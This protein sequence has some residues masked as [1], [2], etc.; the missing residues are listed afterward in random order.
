MWISSTLDSEALYLSHISTPHNFTY[1]L[2]NLPCRDGNI[3]QYH[4]CL[5]L[6]FSLQYKTVTKLSFKPVTYRNMSSQDDEEN[7]YEHKIGFSNHHLNLSIQG[8]LTLLCILTVHFRECLNTTSHSLWQL[9]HINLWV[10]YEC[11]K[12][13]PGGVDQVEKRGNRDTGYTWSQEEGETR[14][15]RKKECYRQSTKSTYVEGAILLST[16]TQECNISS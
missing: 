4:L 14:R 15:T 8:P 12:V 2:P 11:L 9:G 13:V 16:L 3:F 10:H 5:L 6:L 1:F 7:N